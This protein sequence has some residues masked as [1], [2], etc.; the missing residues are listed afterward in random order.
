VRIS[1]WLE[2]PGLNREDCPQFRA[3][4]IF[5]YNESNFTRNQIWTVMNDNNS[6]LVPEVGRGGF[7]RSCLMAQGDV[8]RNYFWDL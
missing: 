1:C 7:L 3:V 5:V 4:I 8:L 2:R 6:K